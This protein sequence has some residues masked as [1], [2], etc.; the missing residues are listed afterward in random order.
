MQPFENFQKHFFFFKQESPKSKLC[1]LFCSFKAGTDKMGT[2]YT[3]LF[4]RVVLLNFYFAATSNTN[5]SNYRAI[6]KKINRVCF[7]AYAIAWV[8]IGNTPTRFIF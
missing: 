1:C 6:I 4:T 2:V 8:A 7:G 3:G 5:D